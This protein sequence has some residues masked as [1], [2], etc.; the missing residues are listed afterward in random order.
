MIKIVESLVNLNF[1]ILTS[2]TIPK[3]QLFVTNS[4]YPFRPPCA[5]DGFCSRFNEVN[6]CVDY[7]VMQQNECAFLLHPR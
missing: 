5:T 4:I 3:N 6:L 1:F 2:K 7:F